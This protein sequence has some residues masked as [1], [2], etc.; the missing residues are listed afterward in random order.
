MKIIQFL[1]VVLLS[2]GVIVPQFNPGARQIALSHSDVA[3]VNDVFSLYNNPAGL[4][5]M[6]WREIGIFYSPSPFGLKELSNG[7]AAYHEPLRFGSISLGLMTYGF[8]LYRENKITIAYSYNYNNSFFGGIAINT[9]TLN[10]INY[11]NTFSVSFDAGILAYITNELKWG[12]VIKNFTRSTFGNEPGHIPVILNSGFSYQLLE[13]LSLN[14]SVEKDIDYP[15][16]F[17]GGIEYDLMEY[18][19]MRIGVSSATSQY[20]AGIGINYSFIHLDYAIISHPD[21]GLT[22]QAGIILHFGNEGT[23]N[24]RIKRFLNK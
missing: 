11:G 1:I 6:N 13:K 23:R 20:S 16:S 22:H 3:L 4:S 21:L 14:L 9:H 15:E 18:L 7:F 10:I 2:A 17:N 12:F 8:D 5:Q 24:E 19:T